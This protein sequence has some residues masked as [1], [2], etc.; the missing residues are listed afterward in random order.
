MNGGKYLVELRQLTYF[1]EVAK[2]EHVT[3]AANSMHIAQSAVSRQLFNLEDELGVN[4]FIRDGRNVKL[5][6]IGRVFL[7]HVEQALNVLDNAK[8]EIEEYLDP[9]RGTIRIGFPSSL[10]AHT[11]PTVISAFRDRHPQVKFSLSQ[12]NYYSLIDRVKTGE[13]D[14]ALLGPV[15]NQEKKITGTTLFTD[16]MVALLPRSH[17]L[18]KNKTINLSQLQEEQFVLFPKGYVLRDII[19]K[20]CN[21]L[22]FQ[23]TV[24]FEGEDIDAI[25]GLVS[26][27]LGVTIIPEVTLLENVPHSTVKVSIVLPEVTRSVGVIIPKDRK[28]LPTEKI[29]YE[30]L[31]D[32]FSFLD[33]F[34]Y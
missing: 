13:I 12:G 23:P 8:R 6:P 34:Q 14:M 9:E 27:G 16:K 2:R 18:A 30:F 25:K 21:Q 29:F 31:K 28:L 17:P 22:G 20:A 26:A 10:A 5:T 19:V 24:S 33:K 32:Y 3:E 15:P 4:L 7:D 11:L 1:M